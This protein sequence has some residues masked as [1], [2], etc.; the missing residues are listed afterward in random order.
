MRGLQDQ[1]GA[2]EVRELKQIGQSRRSSSEVPRE[3]AA[4]KRD[5]KSK[6]WVEG[7]PDSF[8]V[9]VAEEVDVTRVSLVVSF[10]PNC[11]RREF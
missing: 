8:V 11:F 1:V 3:N 2:P 5:V 4:T 9:R 6:S 10:D 7:N